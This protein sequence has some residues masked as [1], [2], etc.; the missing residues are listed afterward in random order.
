[1]SSER[2]C[3]VLR[4][5]NNYAL[6]LRQMEQHHGQLINTQSEAFLSYIIKGN[7]VLLKA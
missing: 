5:Q 7:I 2:K 6:T 1:M 3:D 4:K